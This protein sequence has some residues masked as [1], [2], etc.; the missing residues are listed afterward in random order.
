[1]FCNCNQAKIPNPVFLGVEKTQTTPS[2]L[3]F[4]LPITVSVSRKTLYI[5]LSV[6]RIMCVLYFSFV[7]HQYPS[8]LN[9]TFSSPN[10]P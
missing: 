10:P 1:M 5:A 2:N 3:G 8:S 9:T 7:F 4:E 6:I